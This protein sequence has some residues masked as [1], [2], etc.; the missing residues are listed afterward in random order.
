MNDEDCANLYNNSKMVI[1][2]C[3]NRQ[4]K[5]QVKGRVFEAILCGSLLMEQENSETAKYF[6]PNEEYI[7]WNNFDDL[8]EKVNYFILNDNERKSL[9]E[10]ASLKAHE[11]YSSQNYWRNLLTKAQIIS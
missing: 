8:I 1:N 3:K 6:E 7:P 5:S 9:S 2:F 11:K 10:K 4:N